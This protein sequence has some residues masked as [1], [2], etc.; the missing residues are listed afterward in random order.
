MKLVKDIDFK[1][2]ADETGIKKGR[3]FYSPTARS[4]VISGHHRIDLVC[5]EPPYKEG[6]LL[7]GKIVKSVKINKSNKWV[8]T[9]EE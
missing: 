9:L 3:I 5:I 4:W 8:I 7:E 2:I 6:D 1:K